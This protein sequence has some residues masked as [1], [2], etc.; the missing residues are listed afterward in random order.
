MRL[1]AA[2]GK[3]GA[4]GKT[5]ANPLGCPGWGQPPMR[6]GADGVERE[7]TG[8]TVI[9]FRTDPPALPAAVPPPP[10]PGEVDVAV[11]YRPVPDLPLRIRPPEP[12]PPTG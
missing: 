1:R 11:V 6:A 10:E 9:G 3:V 8:A 2:D 7:Q 5:A 12:L 4:H